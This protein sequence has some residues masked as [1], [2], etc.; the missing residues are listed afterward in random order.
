MKEKEHNLPQA[1]TLSTPE[2]LHSLTRWAGMEGRRWANLGKE[3]A[4]MW[5]AKTGFKIA[6]ASIVGVWAVMMVMVFT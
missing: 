2:A 6:Y 4:S 5:W 1:L 3:V